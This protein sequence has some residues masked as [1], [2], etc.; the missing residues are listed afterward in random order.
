MCDGYIENKQ[1]CHTED[2]QSL[3]AERVQVMLR[4]MEQ[5]YAI[6]IITNNT[7]ANSAIFYGTT[8]KS[9]NNNK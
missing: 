7:T 5:K 2:S 8:L 3:L 4:L 9:P 1:E 6:I